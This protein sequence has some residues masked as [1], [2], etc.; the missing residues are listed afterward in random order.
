MT[1]NLSKVIKIIYT[2]KLKASYN[3][4]M[5]S[6]LFILSVQTLEYKQFKVSQ[7]IK[8]CSMLYFFTHYTYIDIH[9]ATKILIQ[10]LLLSNIL[11]DVT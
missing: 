4:H 2:C 7:F 1:N 8:L 9:I 6:F 10:I 5:V 11:H 3:Y